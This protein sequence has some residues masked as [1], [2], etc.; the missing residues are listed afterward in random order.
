VLSHSQLSGGAAV[1]QLFLRTNSKGGIPISSA[2]ILISVGDTTP[3][4]V[5]C[6]RHP[7]NVERH[8]VRDVVAVDPAVK[9]R[10][11]T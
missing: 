9:C 8:G 3:L 1:D 4:V 5:E 11:A 7:T 2:V 10:S 6:E